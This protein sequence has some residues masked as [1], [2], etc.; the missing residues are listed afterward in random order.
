MC[1]DEQA[2]L[3]DMPSLLLMATL[4]VGEAGTARPIMCPEESRHRSRVA[5]RLGKRQGAVSL[6]GPA[7]LSAP[8]SS[9]CSCAT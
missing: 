2:R 1:Y 7:C 3:G 5:T 6:P 9:R 8:G 4:A